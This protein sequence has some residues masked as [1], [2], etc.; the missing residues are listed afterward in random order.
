MEN[1]WVEWTSMFLLEVVIC[2]QKIT[3]KVFKDMQIYDKFLQSQETNNMLK[4]KKV[5]FFVV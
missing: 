4:I 1:L 2:H 3:S 5:Y